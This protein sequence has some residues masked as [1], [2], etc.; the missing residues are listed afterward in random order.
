MPDDATMKP[1][2]IDCRYWAPPNEDA[3]GECRRHPP[4]VDHVDGEWLTTWPSTNSGDWCGEFSPQ[5]RPPGPPL[6]DLEG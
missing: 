3:P 1:F 6:R 5:A 4:I 2:C